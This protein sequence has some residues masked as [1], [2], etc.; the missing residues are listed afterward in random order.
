MKPSFNKYW[1]IIALVTV[2]NIL[3]FEFMSKHLEGYVADSIVQSSME[4]SLK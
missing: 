2:A 3:I 1:M 4:S